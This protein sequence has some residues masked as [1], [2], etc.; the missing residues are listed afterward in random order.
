MKKTTSSL[1]FSALTRPLDISD[2]QLI[3]V[4]EQARKIGFL[5]GS[6]AITRTV[7]KQAIDVSNAVVSL[8]RDQLTGHILSSAVRAA[9]KDPHKT[10]VSFQICRLPT[11]D[12][13]YRY[14]HR[15]ITLYAVINAGGDGKGALTIMLE[16]EL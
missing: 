1:S 11:A 4:T 9:R 13:P 12:D 7:W 10:C 16:E 3:D 15:T 14:I 8:R 5:C 6:T 2:N